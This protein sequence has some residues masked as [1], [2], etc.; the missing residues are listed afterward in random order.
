MRHALYDGSSNH[1]ARTQ[2]SRGI[3]NLAQ[4]RNLASPACEPPRRDY[5]SHFRVPPRVNPDDAPC[6]YH[7]ASSAVW[8]VC[9]FDIEAKRRTRR[10]VLKISRTQSELHASC[11]QIDG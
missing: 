2:L 1:P 8:G 4:L 11:V 9:Q 3:L 7:Q 6:A 10:K 5:Q